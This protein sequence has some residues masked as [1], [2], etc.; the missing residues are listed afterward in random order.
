MKIKN[1]SA[2]QIIDSRATPTIEVDITLIDGSFGRAA[3]PSGASTG[4]Y[5]AL[6]LRDNDP[7]KFFGKGVLNAV[8]N[9]NN[10]NKKIT[11]INFNS[12]KDLDYFLIEIDGTKNKSSL[13][14]NSILGVSLA[15]A[16][17][18]AN[19][20]NTP[21]FKHINQMYGS[22]MI[23]PRP[24]FNIMNGGRHANW[25]TDIQEFMIIIKNKTYPE[26]LRAA[27]EIF[28][29]LEK[30]LNEKG[31]NTNIGN[32]GGFAPGF[33]TNEEALSIIS[34]AVEK[35]GYSL[36][37]EVFFGID[38][39]ASEFYNKKNDTYILKT[40]NRELQ[41]E[42]WFET[43]KN[44]LNKYPFLSIEDPF[45]EDDWKMWSKFTNEFGDRYQI[46]GDD[47]LVTNVKRIEKG[48]IKKACNSLLVKVNQIGSLT[49]TLE[50]MKK[51]ESASWENIV[52]HRSGET[53]DTTIS[54]IAVGTGA[55]QIK[56]G[57][58]SRGE[59]TAKYNELLRIAEVLK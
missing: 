27:S 2:R 52:S 20:K 51:S 5:E 31:M 54:H 59:R 30:V 35:S 17:S 22:E 19:S 47:L 40:E 24:M 32:E 57:A 55:G 46:V 7:N 39:A 21:L 41:K 16:H 45:S 26:Q 36:G 37:N 44:W 15:F 9:V 33:S 13:G 4:Q 28:L 11:G 8:N 10:L 53:E 6:E 29:K 38:V 48:I 56:T 18:V 12:Q 42:E 25:S 3:V 43:L 34:E 58:P 1:I 49:E 23:L 50:A 14:A